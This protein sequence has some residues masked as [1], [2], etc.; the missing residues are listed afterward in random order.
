MVIMIGDWNAKIHVGS[1]QS[2]KDGERSESGTFFVSLANNKAIT[3]YIMFL[4]RI[5]HTHTLALLWMDKRETRL[6]V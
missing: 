6:I 3:P 5:Y 2:G 1:Q 4:I